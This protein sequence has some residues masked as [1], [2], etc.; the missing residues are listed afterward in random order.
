MSKSLE[1][2]AGC[3]SKLQDAAG[4]SST[5]TDLFPSII[6]VGGQSA[7]KSSIIETI[8]GHSFLPRGQDIVTRCPLKIRLGLATGREVS[9]KYVSRLHQTTEKLRIVFAEEQR[10]GQK[11]ETFDNF[12]DVREEI[13]KRTIK[14]VGE[15]KNVR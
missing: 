12:E 9:N 5:F 8:V 14:R 3:L 6:C 10:Y 4:E 15:S 1:I 13:E 11:K 2:L 7:G